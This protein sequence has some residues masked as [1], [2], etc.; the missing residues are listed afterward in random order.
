[1]GPE[2]APPPEETGE[3]PTQPEA[4]TREQIIGDAMGRLFV[5]T[6]QPA[7]DVDAVLAD[8]RILDQNGGTENEGFSLSLHHWGKNPAIWGGLVQHAKAIDADKKSAAISEDEATAQVRD[9]LHLAEILGMD[10]V[11]EIRG[12]LDDLKKEYGEPETAAQPQSTTEGSPASASWRDYIDTPSRRRISRSLGSPDEPPEEPPSDNDAST[13]T[14]PPS[15]Q[16]N[17]E[18][19]KPSIDIQGATVANEKHPSHNEDAML[20]LPD[21]RIA[22]VFDGVTATTNPLLASQ[23]AS[24]LINESLQGL[25]ELSPQGAEAAIRSALI[26]INNQIHEQARIDSLEAGTEITMGS[27]ASVVYVHEGADGERTAIIGNIG[28]SRVYL[29]R[30]DHLQ[31]VTLDDGFFRNS[32][33]GIGEQAQRELQRKLNNTLNPQELTTKERFVYQNRNISSQCLGQERAVEPRMDT[34]NLLQGDRL[35]VCS[36]GISDNLPDNEMEQILVSAPDNAEAV[37]I[38]IEASQARS[39]SNSQ[40][41]PRA[42]ADDMTAII[43]GESNPAQQAAE[44]PREP[45]GR[46]IRRAVDSFLKRSP[47]KEAASKPGEEPKKP[48]EYHIPADR[49]ASVSRIAEELRTILERQPATS[50]LIVNSLS[51]TIDSRSNPDLS[52]F[53]ELQRQLNAVLGLAG[54]SSFRTVE[55]GQHQALPENYL[56]NHLSILKRTSPENF[57]EEVQLLQ[58]AYSSNPP[59]VREALQTAINAYQDSD[60]LSHHED[61]FFTATDEFNR[62]EWRAAGVDL[63]QLAALHN[64]EYDSAVALDRILR[65]L[66]PSLDDQETTM[67]RFI[68][69][70]SIGTESSLYRLPSRAEINAIILDNF[71]RVFVARNRTYVEN[72]R[73]VQEAREKID[74]YRQA[75]TA[76]AG[77][78]ITQGDSGEVIYERIETIDGEPTTKTMERLLQQALPDSEDHDQKRRRLST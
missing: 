30:D 77:I 65:S 73:L 4:P 66:P 26:N 69:N 48:E 55:A 14:P 5:S 11:P 37:K 75:R 71:A 36:D 25:D 68:R 47:K 33:A 46:I 10:T 29:L 52:R 34:I 9:Y 45:L 38:L 64:A 60:G 8:V 40:E 19:R 35:I 62:Q 54:D 32:L 12:D 7:I 59:E 13:E 3:T 57:D 28:N 76:E 56:A 63:D 50:N 20:M 67:D 18:T 49:K 27:T 74:A 41:Y 22:A 44:Q 43:I 51:A 70:S 42:Q 15:P 53:R 21:R 17:E 31:Q 23:T 16:E 1:M 58:D 24:N 61:A 39:K 78:K 72:R 6:N 2:A